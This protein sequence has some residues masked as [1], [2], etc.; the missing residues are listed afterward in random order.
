M[1]LQA[2]KKE[3]FLP[4]IHILKPILA[5]LVTAVLIMSLNG[6]LQET[7]SFF[8]LLMAPVL[9]GIVLIPFEIDDLRNNIK[10][11]LRR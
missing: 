6:V 1:L 2:A 11:L 5:S 3:G 7:P 10:A 9:F 8:K 4:Q